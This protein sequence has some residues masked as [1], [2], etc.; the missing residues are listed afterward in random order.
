MPGPRYREEF[1]QQAV[2]LVAGQHKP[3]TQVAREIGILRKT[4]AQWMEA[5][6]RHPG[7]PFVGWC[8]RRTE[9]HA[10]GGSPPPS[11]R[12]P[13][14]ARDRKKAVRIVTNDRT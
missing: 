9:E 14:G 2:G 10:L 4:L 8:R 1:K 13:R 7:A 12:Q 11:P 6:R 5:A 3:A